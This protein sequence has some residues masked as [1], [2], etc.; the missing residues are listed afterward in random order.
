MIDLIF[1]KSY[2]TSC[3][4]STNYNI[5]FLPQNMQ[6]TLLWSWPVTNEHEEYESKGNFFLLLE[7]KA[8]LLIFDS[9]SQILHY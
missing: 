2:N 9:E 8:S 5:P 4:H 7:V 1:F 3:F 6:P